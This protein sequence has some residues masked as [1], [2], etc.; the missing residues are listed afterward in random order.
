[1]KLK[2]I[3][4]ESSFL[5]TVSKDQRLKKMIGLMFRHDYTVPTAYHAMVGPMASAPNEEQLELILKILDKNVER[6]FSNTRYGNVGNKY[7]L[8]IARQYADGHINFEDLVG[9]LPDIIGGYY[10][11]SIRNLLSPKDKDINQ[12]QGMNTLKKIN[13]KYRDELQRLASA[14]EIEK[15]KREKK[16]LVLIDDERFF[17]FIPLNYGSCYT[18]NNAEGV[19][20][21]FCTGSSSGLSWFSRYTADGPIISVVDKNNIKDKNGK[22]QIH[23]PTHQ[24]VNAHQ[25]DRYSTRTNAALFKRLF[26]NLMKEI[27]NVLTTRKDEINTEL[28]NAKD[29]NG[30]NIIQ[31]KD[32]VDETI[33]VLQTHFSQAF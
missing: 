6:D 32:P 7:N 27:V 3:I 33:S 12:I 23:A 17:V 31:T 2:H 22:W 10:A 28:N 8:W 19:A 14:Q 5:E 15:H 1:M 21:T 4:T 16:D 29:A 18:F 11:L 25:D 26:P 9:E 30:H 24:I 13:N 20:A